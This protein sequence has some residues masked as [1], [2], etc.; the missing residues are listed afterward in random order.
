MKL[1]LKNKSAHLSDGL[2]QGFTIVA[3]SILSFEIN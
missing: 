3:K 2:L 1:D